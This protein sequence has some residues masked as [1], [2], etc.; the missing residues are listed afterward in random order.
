MYYH[1][2][3]SSTRPA[4]GLFHKTSRRPYWCTKQWNGG[5]FGESNQSCGNWTLYL[6]KDFFV[7]RN[8]HSHGSL[9]WKWYLLYV[10][11]KIFNFYLNF[12][13]FAHITVYLFCILFTFFPSR[14][15]KRMFTV[16]SRCYRCD[17]I[18]LFWY[19]Q[20]ANSHFEHQAK[21]NCILV[22]L[23]GG[24]FAPSFPRDFAI[25]NDR[26]DSVRQTFP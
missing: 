22:L 2:A 25:A 5:H 17:E 8:L 4:W 19:G 14:S 10:M 3:G 24:V 15:S 1:N 21:S 13:R 11:Y 12:V 7:P 9:K 16:N 18:I 20:L 23:R 6:C 26:G